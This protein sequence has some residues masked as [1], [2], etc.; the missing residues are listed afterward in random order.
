PKACSKV[1]RSAR[2]RTATPS[3]ST[4]SST[5]AAFV[6]SATKP[7]MAAG[8][9]RSVAADAPRAARP[10][11]V[12]L[13]AGARLPLAFIGS[14][15]VGLA[16]AAAWMALEPSLVGLPHLHPRVVALVHLWLP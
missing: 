10:V 9:P 1:K 7:A 8:S 13:V 16:A 15:L 2:S 11:S 12:P 5:R 14:G 3:T 6:M 4:P